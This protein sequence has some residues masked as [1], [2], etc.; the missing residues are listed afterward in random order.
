MNLFKNFDSSAI[1]KVRRCISILLML[2]TLSGI[3]LPVIAAAEE[4]EGSSVEIVSFLRNDSSNLRSSELLM[5]KVNG[6]DGSVNELSYKW[7]SNL[8]TYL[9]VY[10]THDMSVPQNTEGEYEIYNSEKRVSRSQ[11]AEF[12]ADGTFT[13]IGYSYASV[14][15]ANI[16]EKSLQGGITVE[17]TDANGDLVGQCTYSEAFEM[18][19]LGDD[20]RNTAFGVFEGESFEIKDLLAKSAIVHISC[21]ACEISSGK[22]TE[23]DEYITLNST[24]N[25]KN[26][27]YT[28]NGIK[29]GIAV[30]EIGVKKSNCKFHKGQEAVATT[31]VNVFK[32]PITET[33]ST[34]LTL[35]N[36]DT[37]CEYFIDGVRG[38][39]N[40]G[41]II[42]DGL[43][44]N[45]EYTVE[46]RGKYQ[47]TDGTEKFVYAY[48]T[49]K[50]KD[51]FTA[52]V[53]LKIDEKTATV[54]EIF[55]NN[56]TLY[57]KENN[58][59]DFIPLSEDT[60]GVYSAKVNN[61]IYN[62]Y[63][64]INGEFTQIA[65]LQLQI[66]NKDESVI[67]QYYN[68]S[69]DPNGGSFIGN[70][71]ELYYIN[72]SVAVTADIPTLDN[73]VFDCW[74]DNDNNY[75]P[76]DILTKK[77]TRNY[78]LTAKWEKDE[79]GKGDNGEESDGIPDKYQKKITFKV[80]NGTWEDKTD[81][82]IT[83]YGTLLDENGNWSVDGTAEIEIPTGMIPNYGYENGAW[84]ITPTTTVNGTEP[85]EYIFTFAKIGD[86]TVTYKEP[87]ENNPPT[88]TKTYVEYGKN[89]QV[90]PNGGKWTFDGKTYEGNDTAT[91]KMEN[92][93]ILPDPTREG[94]VFDGWK[95]E[96]GKNDVAYIFTAQWEKDEVGKGDN[97][98]ESDGIPD[99]YQK[100]ITF[101]VENGTWEDK[102]D[103]PITFYVTL[104]DENGNWSVD[105]TAEIEIPI[106]MIP[107]YGYENGAWNIT[108]TTTVKGAEP[109]E[110]IYI[111]TAIINTPTELIEE[112]DTD[113][114][115]DT[116]TD[117]DTDYDTCT[118][119]H[120]DTDSDSDSDIETTSCK[121]SDSDND[122]TS[123]NNNADKNNKQNKNTN[124]V[125]TQKENVTVNSSTQALKTGD[126]NHTAL[127]VGIFLVSFG[128]I[129]FIFLKRK[130]KK[131]KSE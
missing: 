43:T 77:I 119:S 106:G 19:N 95:K 130:E 107:N 111:F 113:S 125:I 82:P 72:E 3:F 52:S 27:D 17:V 129:G 90:K 121:D 7:S 105:G 64:E 98:E 114:N 9:Y 55:G 21:T 48:V 67:A 32:K 56:S 35:T 102:T 68:V 44:P 58:S 71:S 6:Y 39:E 24:Q 31:T 41:K 1:K 8:G 4:N 83:F 46:V 54:T 62:V 100:K 89:I 22:V 88:D 49:D 61:G 5:A 15:G 92:N 99:K 37:D 80:E 23:G 42:F 38:E 81:T 74:A 53:T 45:T 117:T 51:N 76:N 57:L 13:G 116:E 75:S 70:T 96:N 127:F 26:K 28:I 11:N 16:T 93:I 103:T 79:V 94:Y 66:D 86:P 91:I 29:K 25:S 122:K 124:T 65:D 12:A 110:Y 10:N 84:N 128:I 123:S 2:T 18:P 115:T 60:N 40:D 20:I 63:Y 30:I 50:T 109:I 104:L 14:Y 69:Y 78:T 118:D 108:P 47:D 73:Y 36:L 126:K 97:G 59:D 131:D 34:T 87:V 112:T 101:K 85:I 120:V 33:T